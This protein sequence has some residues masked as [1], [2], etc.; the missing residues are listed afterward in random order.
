MINLQTASAY[1]DLQEV[2]ILPLSPSSP[3]HEKSQAIEETVT[4]SIAQKDRSSSDPTPDDMVQCI[5]GIY[6]AFSR[7]GGSVAHS[8]ELSNNNITLY[9][10]REKENTPPY[11]I[12]REKLIA[13]QKENLL[14]RGKL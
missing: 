3:S 14:L 8:S 12:A 9:I 1:F 6:P 4:V 2:N 13:M 5:W 10:R 11:S 7:H